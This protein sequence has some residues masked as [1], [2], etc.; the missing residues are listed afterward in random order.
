MNGM[1][2]MAARDREGL[3]RI[4]R[5]YAEVE[6][7]RLDSPVYTD[8]SF[9]VSKDDQLLELCLQIDPGAGPSRIRTVCPPAPR[10]HV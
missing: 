4:F 5:Y 10:A 9:G 6:T 2:D 8:Y 3:S 1:P 7:P